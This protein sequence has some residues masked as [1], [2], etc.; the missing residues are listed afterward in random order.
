MNSIFKK[1]YNTIPYK[2]TA[3]NVIKSLG[4]APKGIYR[5]LS[6]HGSFHVDIC[7]SIGFEINHFGGIIETETYWMGLF[8]TWEKDTG[9]IWLELC[10]CS[11]TIFDIGAN[12]GIYSLVASALNSDAK[13]VAFEPSINTFHKLQANN[14]LNQFQI[15]TEQLAISNKNHKQVFYDVPSKNQ[16]S[17]SLSPDKLK[18]SNYS[19][20]MLEYEV[21]TVTL[22]DYIETNKIKSLDLIKMDIELHEPEAI[23]GLGE[24]LNNYKPIVVIEILRE[25]IAQRLNEIVDVEDYIIFHLEDINKAV[26]FDKFKAVPKLWNFVFFHKDR[27]QFVKENTSLFKYVR[28]TL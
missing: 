28:D 2:K 3:F 8:K 27:E 25:S 9:W 20:K 18:N 14:K 24:Y 15:K 12:T 17:A 22:K 10:Q 7:Q 26:R 23:E 19:G 11:N 21:D 16:T 13:V 6:F 5:K 1:F 4:I